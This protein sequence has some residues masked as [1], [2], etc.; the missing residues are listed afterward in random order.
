MLIQDRNVSVVSPD[1][2]RCFLYLRDPAYSNQNPYQTGTNRSAWVETNADA[3]KKLEALK[4]SIRDSY[5]VVG[6]YETPQGFGE[7]VLEK[8][9]AAIAEDFPR[10]NLPRHERDNLAHSMIA[11]NH[12]RIQFPR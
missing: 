6:E 1:P 3:K 5:A 10:D 11:E 2:S 7:Q 4:A 8:L 9:K 12:A